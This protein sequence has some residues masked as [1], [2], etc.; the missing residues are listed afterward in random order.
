MTPSADA[1]QRRPAGVVA[2][3]RLR[4]ALGE[5]ATS[6]TCAYKFGRRL[7]TLNGLTRRELIC[8]RWT[9]EPEKFSLDP[10][11]RMPGLDIRSSGHLGRSIAPP[12]RASHKPAD[13]SAHR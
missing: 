12:Q 3:S 4:H 10:I 1:D 8:K 6:P 11:N 5:L 2:R 7:K 9:I 13:Q